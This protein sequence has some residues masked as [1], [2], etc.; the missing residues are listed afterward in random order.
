MPSRQPSRR[1]PSH[2]VA[3]TAATAAAAD[4]ARAAASVRPKTV[5]AS[6]ISQY[7]SGGLST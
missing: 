1:A 6:A 5:K 3:A 4:T 7:K 2:A